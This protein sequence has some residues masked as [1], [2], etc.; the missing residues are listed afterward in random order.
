V[1]SEIKVAELFAGVGGFRLGL[2]GYHDDDNPQF[3]MPAA[4]PFMTIWA[5]QWEPPGT[6]TKQ[7]AAR[8]YKARFGEDSLVNEDINKVLDAAEAGDIDIPDVDMIVGGF[9]CQDYSVAKPLSVAQGINGKKGVLWWDIY[10]ILNMKKPKYVLLENVDRLLKSPAS[11]RGRDF[12]IMLSC[13]AN[14]GYSVE[15]HVV[16]SAEYGFPQ[17]RKRVYIFAELTD[18]CWDLEDRLVDGVMAQALPLTLAG[19][20]SEFEIEKDPYDVTE[21]FGVGRKTSPFL[22]A[23]VMQDFKVATCD[24]VASYDGP[25]RVLGDVLV[26]ESEVPEEFFIEDDKLPKWEYLK[27]SKREERI[28]KKTG[29]A[30]TYSEGKM[31]FPDLPENPA[32]TILTGE[33]GR[34]ASRF[35]HVVLTDSG[36]YRRLVPD[37]LDQLQGFPKGWTDTG[38]TD[39]H[40]AF[41]M[42]NA[43][44]VG[45][46]HRIGREIG[47]RQ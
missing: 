47:R 24:Y 29:Y 27:G 37:E 13:F 43:L 10:R 1:A 9:P 44:V 4:G 39:G 2:E 12:A 36:R 40:R 22:L 17:R 21:H 30:Y 23:G 20:V 6:E 11:Q 33:G 41:C 7:F 14:L 46:V 25:R 5:N 42:G 8:C 35:K 16:N 18:E 32:R 3:E 34:G 19:P 38:M 28:D 26:D 45:V 31:A 15:W